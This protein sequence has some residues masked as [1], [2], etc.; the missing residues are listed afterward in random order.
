[1]VQRTQDA[2]C[3]LARIYVQVC[4]VY[5]VQ[6]IWLVAGPDPR[7]SVHACHFRRR[8]LHLHRFAAGMDKHCVQFIP[9]TVTIFNLGSQP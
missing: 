2:T 4:N 7:Q 3:T 6:R 8:C 1:M 5:K 9:P